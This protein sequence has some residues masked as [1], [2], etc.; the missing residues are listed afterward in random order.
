FLHFFVQDKNSEVLLNSIGYSNVSI[1]GDTRFDRVSQI[2]ERDNT[3]D[4]MSNFKRD[5]YCLV[6]GSTW[7][8]DEELLISYINSSNKPMKY[9]LAPH[10][11]KEKHLDN[12][13]S[14]LTKKSIL[15]SRI[16]DT[17]LSDYEVL[18]VDTIGLLTKI[19]SY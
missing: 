19:Y 7:P 2:L 4:F 13:I 5:Q 3:L 11:I 10:N 1:S 17:A 9:V 18:I 16:G 6:A 15:Y 14:A 12:L 8:E